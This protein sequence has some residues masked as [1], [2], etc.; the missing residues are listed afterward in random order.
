MPTLWLDVED[1]FDYA[2]G[3][4]RPSGIQR[5]SHEIY[6]ALQERETVRFVRHD[7]VRQT[8]RIVP[9]RAV[10]EV[11]SR[12]AETPAV[13]PAAPAAIAAEPSGRQHLRQMVYRLPPDFRRRVVA[14]ARQ[15]ALACAA[16][17]DLL[18]FSA[19]A[20]VAAMRRPAARKHA[21]AEPAGDFAALVRPGDVLAALGAPWRYPGYA[22]LIGGTKRRFGV[23]FAF[24]AYDIIPLRRPEWF[25]PGLARAFRAWFSAVLP[26]ADT[27]FAIS[28]FTAAD[29]ARFAAESG[30]AL[31]APV[32]PIP[33]G[34]G[35]ATVAPA[36]SARLPPPGFALF[37]STIEA[38]KNHGLLVRVWRRLLDERP[39]ERVPMLVFAGRFGWLV[40]DL[41]QQLAN[42]GNLGG[43]IRIVEDASDAELASLYQACAFTLFPSFYEGWGLPVTESLLFG[44][45]C[46]AARASSL[47]EAGGRLAR[48][49]DPDS[50]TDAYAAIRA[51]LDDPDDF[52]AWQAEIVRAFVPM[53]WTATGEAILR[54]LAVAVPNDLP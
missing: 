41:R 15:Q 32:A 16:L 51:A 7:P 33:I 31:A 19:R 43:K 29:V 18:A 23:R 42:T 49:F 12:L 17:A 46:F 8:F 4:A 14:T 13:L 53:P 9:W 47:P 3:A 44:K 10:A 1:L 35:F 20:A 50:A 27:V 26:L 5:L 54:H 38:R 30:I 37:V 28:R 34:S 11:F 24:L 6:R 48:Y 40:E 22:G 25:D 39:A 52:R 21:T 45:P 2:A 36:A